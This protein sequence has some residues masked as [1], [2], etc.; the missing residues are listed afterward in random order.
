MRGMPD[1]ASQT[2]RTANRALVLVGEA[3]VGEII[4]LTVS[5]SSG[6]QGNYVVGTERPLENTHTQYQCTVQI[7]RFITAVGG[8]T[9]DGQ[10]IFDFHSRLT[11]LPLFDIVVEE[12]EGFELWAVKQVTLGTRGSA[13][14]ANQNV[15]QNLSGNGLYMS[16]FEDQND[17][18]AGG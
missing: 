15:R 3:V 8:P 14:D 5:E 9:I 1:I 13:V 11:N 10:D 16:S 6:V 7:N 2:I 18:G 17:A 12:G 4:G